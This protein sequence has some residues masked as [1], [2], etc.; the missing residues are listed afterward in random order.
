MPAPNIH[1]ITTDNPLD[2]QQFHKLKAGL[3]DSSGTTYTDFKKTLKPN[4][5]VV[6][7]DI[8]FAWAG[9][10]AVVLISGLIFRISNNVISLLLILPVSAMLGYIM[11]GLVNFFHEA[12]HYN[13]SGN[14]KLNDLLANL[15]IGIFI[16]QGIKNYRLVHWQHHVALGTTA[17]TER[18]YF[19]SL[20]LRFLFLSLTGISAISFFIKR[21]AFVN[22]K[23][24]ARATD[25]RAE[26]YFM[27][28]AG[29]AFHTLV[30]AYCYLSA[31]YGLMAVWILA[32][33]SFYPFFNRL[34]QLIEH[35]SET[36][37]PETNYRV[38]D[39]GKTNRLFGNSFIDR[40]FG[41]A[42]FNRH[43]LHHLEPTVSYT[44]LNDLET[45]L[46]D[47]AL[48]ASLK[49]QQSTYFST[50]KKLIGR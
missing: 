20:N 12:A 7:R 6:W 5:R 30:L 2:E 3:T 24:Q 48:S 10:I 37:G 18:S 31:Q 28:A 47:T 46:K 23:Q 9:I 19:E 34:R 17:D 11:A 35:R 38:T 32:T 50:F 13:I 1:I 44:R 8:S 36:A 33:G 25:A 15:F 41:S 42:G 39:H 45:F 16:G 29:V 14:K 21:A 49:K 43:L 26:K 40:T 27:L 4:Y 22:G